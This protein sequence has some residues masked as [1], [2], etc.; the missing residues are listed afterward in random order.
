M[1]WIL[2]LANYYALHPFS[3][4]VHVHEFDIARFT[5]YDNDKL[6]HNIA[7]NAKRCTPRIH[8]GLHGTILIALVWIA[9]DSVWQ[10]FWNYISD[11]CVVYECCR[12]KLHNELLNPI[13]GRCRMDFIDKFMIEMYKL[14]RF[15]EHHI[16][17]LS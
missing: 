13:M 10:S 11:S 6:P 1:H 5:F 14:F 3:F 16:S 9:S 17:G 8:S 7:T 15:R 12:V 2:G 4:H